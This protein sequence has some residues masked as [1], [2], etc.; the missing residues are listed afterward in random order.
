MIA[1]YVGYKAASVAGAAVAAAAAF[2]PSFIIILVILPV[3]ERVRKL[4]WMRAVM[5]G[6]GPAVIGVLAVSLIRLAPTA[7]PD[8]F[9]IVIFAATL[10]VLMVLRGGV[11]KLMIAG[12]VLGVLRSHL[13][14]IPGVRAAGRLIAT[15]TIV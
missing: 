9:A 8:L 2:L 1:A 12:A 14:V 4:A 6:M 7:V 3:L 15:W 11:F 10:V 13:P 5:K